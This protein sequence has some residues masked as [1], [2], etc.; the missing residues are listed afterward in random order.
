MLRSIL[1]VVVLG[2]SLVM[3]NGC[4]DDSSDQADQNTP[5]QT[6]PAPPADQAPPAPPADQS[7]NME[8]QTDGAA[9]ADQ[10]AKEEATGDDATARPDEDRMA[11][12]D[13]AP[14]QGAASGAAPE[15]AAG[16]EAGGGSVQQ[17][18]DA[19][20]NIPPTKLVQ[21]VKK[22]DLKNPYADQVDKVAEDGHHIFLGLSCNGCHGGGGGGGMC[23]PLTNPVWVYGSDDDTLFRLVTLGSDALQKDYGLTRVGSENVVG[24]MPAM[25]SAIK[26][27]DDLWKIISWIRTINPTSGQAPHKV[28]QPPEFPE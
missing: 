12:N 4:D 21:E 26:S 9:T 24:P 18:A 8:G 5:A 7:S 14:D 28:E 16:G 2:L 27:S 10:A 23:P 22:G 19:E 1:T 3:L 17:T 11:A 13:T 25:G 15:S 6:E 20:A